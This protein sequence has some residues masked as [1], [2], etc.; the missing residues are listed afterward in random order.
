MN[1]IVFTA[2]PLFFECKNFYFSDMSPYSFYSMANLICLIRDSF[3][4]EYELIYRHRPNCELS[5][6]FFSQDLSRELQLL[7]SDFKDKYR[8]ISIDSKKL[9]DNAKIIFIPYP[10]G[11]IV[12][13]YDL[14]RYVVVVYQSHEDYTMSHLDNMRFDSIV[15]NNSSATVRTFTEHSPLRHAF[16]SG[17]NSNLINQIEDNIFVIDGNQSWG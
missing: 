13:S 8:D 3:F 9:I 15:I 2:N 4:V 14:K 1:W 17:I 7:N 16:C 10:S 11:F 5:N 6:P 12:E